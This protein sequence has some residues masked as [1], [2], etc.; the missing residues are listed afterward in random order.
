VYLNQTELLRHTSALRERT[1]FDCKKSL[2]HPNKIMS[3]HTAHSFRKLPESNR[4]PQELSHI[5]QELSTEPYVFS[6]TE[7]ALVIHKSVQELLSFT[8]HD[9]SQH[10]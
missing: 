5:T 8:Q 4:F 3:A 9:T 7:D 2:K 10:M 1:A 6:F